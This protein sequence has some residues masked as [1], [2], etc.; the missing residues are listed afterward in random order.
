MGLRRVIKRIWLDSKEGR[1]RR[2]FG[3]FKGLSRPVVLPEGSNKPRG[4]PGMCVEVPCMTWNDL[5]AQISHIGPT[6]G[7]SPYLIS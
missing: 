3:Y 4:V 2:V 6:F 5:M 1:G 7:F